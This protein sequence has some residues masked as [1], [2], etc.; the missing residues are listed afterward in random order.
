MNRSGIYRWKVKK[1][2]TMKGGHLRVTL[3]GR[4]YGV[5][6]KKFLAHRL[7][8]LAFVGDCPLDKEVCRH[9]D[10]DPGNNLLSNL[11]W[12][13]HQENAD[14]KIK[15]G[16]SNKGV[17]MVRGEQVGSAVFTEKIVLKMRAMYDAGTHN[18]KQIARIFGGNYWT[19]INIL[20]RRNWKHI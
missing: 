11:A 20:N 8:L 2:Y 14:D 19:V 3:S 5:P 10:G 4:R 17:A 18:G 12:G 9:L 1:P 6:C 15:H 7:V 13:T 16:R